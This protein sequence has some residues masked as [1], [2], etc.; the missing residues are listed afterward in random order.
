M[1]MLLLTAALADRR[2]LERADGVSRARFRTIFEG[3]IVP[4]VIWRS[5]GTILE[6]NASFFE[7]TGYR[8]ADLRGVQLLTHELFVST[9]GPQRRTG[10][11]SLDS[12]GVAIEGQLRERHRRRIPLLTHRHPL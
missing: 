11:F 7:L 5:D 6:A 10:P 12:G 1:T 2:R 3:N 8:R 4:T 9:A